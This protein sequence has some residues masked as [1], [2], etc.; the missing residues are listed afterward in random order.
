MD[1]GKESK[2]TIDRAWLD[3]IS[4]LLYNFNNPR[5]TFRPNLSPYNAH[6]EPA[7]EMIT[8]HFKL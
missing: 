1:G 6:E 2:E 3:L 8:F 5:K 4:D 7:K